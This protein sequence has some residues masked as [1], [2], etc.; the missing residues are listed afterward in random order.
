[1][2][3]RF[4]GNGIDAGSRGILILKTAKRTRLVSNY[5][6]GN[7]IQDNSISL[8]LGKDITQEWGSIFI[9]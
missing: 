3:N 9:R 7:T 1:M 2:N 5:F 8:A 4:E 6:S